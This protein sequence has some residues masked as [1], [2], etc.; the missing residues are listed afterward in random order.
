M[1]QRQTAGECLAW[2]HQNSG[3]CASTAGAEL[4]DATTIT[5]YSRQN[6]SIAAVMDYKE[7]AYCITSTDKCDIY[8][9]GFPASATRTLAV[10]AGRLIAHGKIKNNSGYSLVYSA[11]TKIGM[12]GGPVLDYAGYLMGIHARGDVK[13]GSPQNLQHSNIVEINQGVALPCEPD[14]KSTAYAVPVTNHSGGYR[15]AS[16]D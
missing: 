11:P 5:F 7:G 3:R 8:V 13:A 9:A 1:R 10:T 2:D 4:L 12:S 16:C 14:R 15:V 6:Y